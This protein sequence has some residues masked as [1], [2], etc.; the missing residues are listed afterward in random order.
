MENKAIKELIKEMDQSFE[1]FEKT[2]SYT[3]SAT[4][5]IQEIKEVM[6]QQKETQK[7]KKRS[8]RDWLKKLWH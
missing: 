7:S 8:W 1:E 5:L 4:P 6:D 3:L 2:M